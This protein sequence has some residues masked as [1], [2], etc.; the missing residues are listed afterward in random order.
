[1]ALEIQLSILVPIYNCEAFLTKCLNSLKAIPLQNIEIILINDGSTDKSE[2]MCLEYAKMD[3]RFIYHYKPNGGV[4]SARNMAYS[5]A[6]GTYI[7]FVDSD[8][9]IVPEAWP[10]LIALAEKH[11]VEIVNFGYSFFTKEEEVIPMQTVFP[12]NKV[13]QKSDFLELLKTNSHNSRL[14]WFL[15]TN[16]YRKDL[17]DR[18]GIT[19]NE[20]LL[21]G[22]EDAIF[23]L[24]CYLNAKGIYSIPDSIY[25]Y[26]YNPDSLITQKVKK[27]MIQTLVKQ[28]RVRLKIYEKH[29][30]LKPKYLL[31]MSNYY[32]EHKL[33]LLLQNVENHPVKKR[34]PMLIE[35]RDSEVYEYC[36]EKYVFNDKTYKMNKL[37]IYLFKNRLFTVM[38]LIISLKAYRH[39]K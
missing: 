35:M 15:W 39:R 30:L 16:L 27:E 34:K 14:I 23:N 31:D 37:M 12:K 33:F 32:I 13:L 17:L 38:L 9:N 10:N 8:D 6:R 26:N 36:F 21:L 29:D 24:Q 11:Q 5:L 18:N 1:M 22:M 4:S 28:F 2:E 19:F 7:S 3:S 25:Y 20:T